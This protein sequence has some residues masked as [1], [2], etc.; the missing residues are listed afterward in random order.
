MSKAFTKESDTAPDDAIR[1]RG[2][3]LPE[4][5]PNYLTAAGARALR[6]E[7]EAAPPPPRPPELED[8]LRELG[9]H[10]AAAEIVE[11]PVDRERVGFGAAV[12]VEDGDGARTRYR[13]VGAIEAAPREGAIGWQ[14]PV[15][16]ALLG[17]RVGDPVT[18]PRGD[19]V[20]VVAIDY[21]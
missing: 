18:L 9:D 1:R 7:L 14:S 3:P 21:D 5:V 12:T 2:V 11:A 8:R 20:E 16:R 6:A 10:L 13:I 15:A 17:A 4:G 19:E